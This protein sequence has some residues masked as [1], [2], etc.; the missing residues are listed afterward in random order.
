MV[1]S[2]F[3]VYSILFRHGL[4]FTRDGIGVVVV[5]ITIAERSDPLVEIKLTES[6]AECRF[7]LW[8]HEFLD[9]RSR[10]R[11]RKQFSSIGPYSK[12]LRI[13]FYCA[14]LVLPLHWIIRD[15]VI[16]G[17]GRFKMETFWF[18]LLRFRRAYDHPYDFTVFAFRWFVSN[19]VDR[20]ALDA[21]K[22]F[23]FFVGWQKTNAQ[24]K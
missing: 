11:G 8:I 24:Q 4:V 19:A 10:C 12:D 21:P 7:L 17:N 15:G 1:L 22:K 5:W 2:S 13:N 20:V 16:S 3:T 23:Q 6:E 18:F 14:W 9:C